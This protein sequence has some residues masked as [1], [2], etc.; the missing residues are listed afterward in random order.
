M[1]L[2]ELREFFGK[3]AYANA[4][5]ITIDEAENGRAVCSFQIQEGHLNGRQSVQ[6][7]AIFTLADFTFAVAAH[8]KDQKAVSLEN[9]ISFM[10]AT[11]GTKLIAT[12]RE[13]TSTRKVCFYE[14][15]VTDDLGCKIARMSVTGYM[16]Q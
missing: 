10:H 7:G 5:G 15:D 13:V 4:C 6:G 3:D 16:L 8:S 14:V 11:K 12:A 9:Q 1:E 2:E